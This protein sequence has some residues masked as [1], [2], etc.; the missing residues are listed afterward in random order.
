MAVPPVK[1]CR[2]TVC[3]RLAHVSTRIESGTRNRAW[4][5]SCD[6]TVS[7]Y[8]KRERYR[9]WTGRHP[10]NVG[11]NGLSKYEKGGKL[12]FKFG[13]LA[14][15]S[16]G[17]QLCL[18]GA[19]S[20]AVFILSATIFLTLIVEVEHAAVTVANKVDHSVV[21]AVHTAEDA[22]TRTY[23]TI[24]HKINQSFINTAVRGEEVFNTAKDGILNDVVPTAKTIVEDTYNTAIGIGK[25]LG[26]SKDGVDPTKL[27][28]NVAQHGLKGALASATAKSLLTNVLH[29]E[30]PSN[31]VDNV[32]SQLTNGATVPEVVFN[33]F[34]G[35][36]YA[37][38][39]AN[40]AQFVA[41]LYQD[42]MGRTGEAAGQKYWTDALAAGQSHGQII[43][44]FLGSQEFKNIV[45]SGAVSEHLYY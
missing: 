12:L 15:A 14:N 23:S 6:N 38:R 24:A 43:N 28:D 16:R 5:T 2:V 22:V 20:V 34:N 19:G 18:F 41:N 35:P 8:H 33:I 17:E 32:A 30:P 9:L 10:A 1:I 11:S 3:L 7:G 36:D 44:I 40:D 27:L 13:F 29:K 31:Q 25:N 42:I 39:A 37:A 21:A 4:T 45:G 26:V